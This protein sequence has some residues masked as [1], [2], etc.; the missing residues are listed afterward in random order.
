MRTV[1]LC[2]AVTCPFLLRLREQPLVPPLLAK[3]Y[4]LHA[5]IRLDAVNPSRNGFSFLTCAFYFRC[6]A[7][8][9]FACVRGASKTSS[10]VLSSSIRY[11]SSCAGRK[12]SSFGPYRDWI[13]CCNMLACWSTLVRKSSALLEACVSANTQTHAKPKR[14]GKQPRRRSRDTTPERLAM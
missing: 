3:S 11:L 6:P 10:T 12:K 13:P 7:L 8:R 1:S 9:Q 4:K 14:W 5:V 2:I